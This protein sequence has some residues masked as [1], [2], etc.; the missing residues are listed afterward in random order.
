MKNK[1]QQMITKTRLWKLY[2]VYNNSDQKAAS[3]VAHSIN[4]HTHLQLRFVEI[5]LRLVNKAVRAHSSR[6]QP[7]QL[8]NTAIRGAHLW[9]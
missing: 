9:Y 8:P 1:P 2:Y 6:T 5:S 3:L 7:Q 4:Q